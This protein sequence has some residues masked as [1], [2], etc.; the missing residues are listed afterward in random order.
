VTESRRESLSPKVAIGFSLVSLALWVLA[1]A[2]GGILLA[3]LS[4]FLGGIAAARIWD[5][6][7]LRNE[8]RRRL[9]TEELFDLQRRLEEAQA[10]I[11]QLR[12]AAEIDEG[13]RLTD[14]QEVA[15]DGGTLVKKDTDGAEP[16]W[17]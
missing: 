6:L 4:L 15:I 14:G 7:K 16:R 2:D 3:F 11:A 1:D 9:P 8:S 10:E 17:R 12:A 13:L 5:Y